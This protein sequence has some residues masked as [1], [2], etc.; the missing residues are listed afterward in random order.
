MPK[1]WTGEAVKRLHNNEITANE[2]AKEMDITVTYLSSI[3]NS[4]REPTGIEERVNKAIDT[5]LEKRK[6]REN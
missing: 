5:I 1:P 6:A 2:L 4:K 3:L